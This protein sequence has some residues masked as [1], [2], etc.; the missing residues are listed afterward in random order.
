M[1]YMFCHC[2]NL[3]EININIDNTDSRKYLNLK[4]MFSGCEKLKFI[5]LSK[6]NLDRVLKYEHNVLLLHILGKSRYNKNEHR[7]C[8]K[9]VLY[10]RLLF[11]F[12][13]I[14]F[15]KFEYE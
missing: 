2:S 11:K 12:K 7:K 6:L 9:Y 3:E 13:R 1:S 15:A 14:K 4:E 8:D 5:D 10:V